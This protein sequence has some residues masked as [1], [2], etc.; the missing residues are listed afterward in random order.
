MKAPKLERNVVT[1][2]LEEYTRLKDIE[3]RLDAMYAA[4]VDNWQ[5]MEEAIAILNEWRRED[6]R[7]E[8]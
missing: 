2:K 3:K 6:E 7:K 5:G 4:G 1:I 8:S